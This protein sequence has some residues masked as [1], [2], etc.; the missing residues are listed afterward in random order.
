MAESPA[1]PSNLDS[2]FDAASPLKDRLDPIRLTTANIV[3]ILKLPLS[4]QVLGHNAS[5]ESLAQVVSGETSYTTF[6]AN[7]ACTALQT[8]DDLTTEQKQSQLLYIGLAALFS[9]LQSNVTGPPLEFNSAQI[10]LPSTLQSE[11]TTLKTVRAKV[12]RDLTVD[13]E[14]AY[15]L[16]PNP[17]LFAVA[18]ALLVDASSDGPLVAKTAHMCINFLYQKM[19]SEVTSTLQDVIYKDV[20]V[21]SKADLDSDEKGRFL[22][23]R[24]SIYIYHG[25]DVKAWEDIDQA[26]KVRKFEFTLTRRLGKRTKFQDCDISQLV[27]LAKSADNGTIQSSEPSGPKNLDLN[28]DTLLEAI[29]FSDAKPDE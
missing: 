7:Q 20:E 6:V 26:A 8:S 29:S 15:K 1:Y 3:P 24:A 12:I 14:A 11:R 13:G 18:K 2:I 10:I 5:D 25:F 27:V 17:E 16:T 4:H 19:L 23:E 28:D 9:F 21:L 22:L